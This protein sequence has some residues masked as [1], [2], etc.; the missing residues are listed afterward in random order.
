MDAGDDVI[1]LIEHVVG[2]IEPSSFEHVGLHAVEETEIDSFG[3]PCLV[4]SPDGPS[5]IEQVLSRCSVG[6]G[7]GRRMIGDA[8]P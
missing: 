5:L 2:M 1:Q 3:L 4:V 6:H 8:H 7:Q